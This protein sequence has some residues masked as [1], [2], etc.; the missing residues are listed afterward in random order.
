MNKIRF[1]ALMS[2]A[3]IVASTAAPAMANMPSVFRDAE[4]NVYLTGHTPQSRQ[5]MT[6]EGMM[7]SRDFQ[8]NACGAIILRNSSTNPIA[9]TIR[10]GGTDVSAAALPTQLM[11]NCLPSGQ[12]EEA[13]PNNFKTANGDVVIV[14][15][16][17]GSYTTVQTPQNRDRAASANACGIVRFTNS[18]SFQHSPTTIVRYAVNGQMQSPRPISDLELQEPPLCSRGQLYVP[19]SWLS[20]S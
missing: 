18:T 13:R 19:L 12:F 3:A 1:G 14:G 7:R 11:P 16:T 4:N 5:T 8:A 6:Y 20:G 17:P 9:G 15:R 2:A 10:V